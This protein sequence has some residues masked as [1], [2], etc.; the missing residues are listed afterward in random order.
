MKLHDSRPALDKEETGGLACLVVRVRDLHQTASSWQ[1]EISSMTQLSLRGAKRRESPTKGPRDDAD[2]TTRVCA[3]K[4][5]EMC[6]HEVLDKVSCSVPFTVPV[7]E[8]PRL[9]SLF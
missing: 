1:E 6:R 7:K 8:N 3:D 4:L 9:T 5:T 2:D